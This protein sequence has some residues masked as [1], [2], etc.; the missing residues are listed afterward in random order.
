MVVTRNC[1]PIK[2]LCFLNQ[3]HIYIIVVKFDSI[4]DPIE[5]MGHWVSGPTG[6]STIDSV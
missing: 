6:E 1:S 2:E 5:V 3:I 4:I